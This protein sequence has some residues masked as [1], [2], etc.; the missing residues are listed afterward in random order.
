MSKPAYFVG[1]WDLNR[2]LACVPADP[3]DGTIVMVESVNKGS[4]LPFHRKKLV[5]VLSAGHH[6]AEELRADGYDVE[7]VRA[8]SY[9]SG[10][11]KHVAARGSSR[12]IAMRSREWGLERALERAD[13]E[14]TFGVPLEMN[15]AGG[16]GA[17]FL[18]T[19]EEFA[20]WA[21][22]RKTLRMDHFYRWMR[23]KFD[24][25]ID[26]RGKPIGGKW[27]Y[28]AENR[29]PAKGAV[30]PERAGRAP[31]ALTREWMERIAT[32]PG[33]FGR[34]DGFDWPVTRADAL[35]E[36][37]AFFAL[38]ASGFGQYQDA[39]LHGKPFMWH[40]HLA[41]A[42]NLSLV[43]PAE[44]IERALAHYEAGGM[45]LN[46]VE[47]FVRQIA[48]WREFIRGAYWE[49][50]PEL[51][52][53]NLL[54][55]ERALPDF[56]WEPE[57][58]AMRCVSDSAR[59][60]YEHGYA[61]HIQRL[62]VLGN[63]ALIAG[64]RP[65]EVSHWFWAGFVDAYEWVELPNVHSMAL[66]ADDSLTT[67]PYASSA[68]Y[69]NRMSDYCSGC[70]Y[71]HKARTGPDA[72]PFNFLFWDFIGRNRDRLQ[73]NPRLGALYRTWDRWE[74]DEQDRIKSEARTFLEAMPVSDYGWTFDDDQC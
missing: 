1:P 9:V 67:K 27:S 30:P 60:V 58:T 33:H 18:I 48:G 57:K 71:N 23:K 31:D 28:D 16:E 29:N 65:I 20:G 41:A 51:R 38:R 45:P 7:Y 17:H 10:I 36:L 2:D 66:F 21:R 19:R 56:Y 14:E 53:S 55:A 49:L 3:R 69:I 4:A 62:M 73:K 25:L 42:M 52:D 12:V 50:M 74:G 64:L 24:Y 22:G 6:F 72:C 11:K 5:L 32:W 46:A 44:I 26:E 37:D 39:L 70:A 15:E 47:G 43:G 63:F 68:A 54:G 59:A 35:A 8:R 13:E 40:A 34:V 61:H